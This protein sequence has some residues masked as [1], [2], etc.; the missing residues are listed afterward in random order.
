M[1]LILGAGCS[2]YVVAV[3]GDQSALI[4]VSV[5]IMVVQFSAVIQRR[6]YLNVKTVSESDVNTTQVNAKPIDFDEADEL[7]T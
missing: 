2:L 6:G 4:N 1:N 7:C 3:H 5:S